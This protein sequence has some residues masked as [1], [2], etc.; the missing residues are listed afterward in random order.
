[1]I[2]NGDASLVTQLT[3]RL[4]TLLLLIKSKNNIIN[5]EFINSILSGN[6][7]EIIETKR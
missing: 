2:L 7:K 1:M 6:G 5:D 3:A 4:D